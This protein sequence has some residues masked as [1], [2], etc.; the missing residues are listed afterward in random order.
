LH[1]AR[2]DAAHA[3]LHEQIADAAR[4]EVELLR[5]AVD[6]AEVELG[7]RRERA[8]EQARAVAAEAEAAAEIA[9]AERELARQH[10]L[11]AGLRM[12]LSAASAEVEAARARL[13]AAHRAV[14]RAASEVRAAHL[15]Q[16]IADAAALESELV[17]AGQ[18]AA[19]L[20]IQPD[21][22]EKL[23]LALRDQ[24]LEE[25]R[26]EAAAVTITLRPWGSPSAADAAPDTDGFTPARVDPP[27]GTRTLSVD[28]HPV[29]GPLALRFSGPGELRLDGVATLSVQ[30]GEGLADRA[31]ALAA[32]RARVA[33]CLTALDA[34]TAEAARVRADAWRAL[35]AHQ[36][37][38][39]GRL[40]LI[41]PEGAAPLQA[42]LAGLR[43]EL[44]VASTAPTPEDAAGE[45]RA[46]EARLAALRAQVD[47]TSARDA[48]MASAAHAKARLRGATT[49]RVRL[50]ARLAT[51]DDTR[52][53]HELA[54]QRSALEAALTRQTAAS[55]A[56]REAGGDGPARRVRE[57][58]LALEALRARSADAARS[59]AE[60]TAR[61]LAQAGLADDLALAEEAL[62]SAAA[63][64]AQVEREAAAAHALADA[65]EA[66]LASL[67]DRFTEPVRQVITPW[68]EILFPGSDLAVD[69]DSGQ[70]TG[71][72]TGSVVERFE[73]LSA[74]AREQLAIL[75][76]LGIG[77]V[78]AG[79]RRLPV[80]LDDALVNADPVRR[81]R[82]LAVL[83][84]ACRR[85][86][87]LVFTC[88]DADFDLLGADWS[89]RVQGR[90]ARG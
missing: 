82:M 35:I 53:A 61:L 83:R 69:A 74:G 22:L 13:D 86:Q 15:R 50:E 17:S 3:A 84:E 6:R 51:G 7:Q 20:R 89:A 85:L 5:E 80:I 47:D 2:R 44:D 39:R 77:A 79:P 37:S 21:L 56:L 73:D 24:E 29:L 55:A 1:A 67:Q 23:E 78:L 76:R 9:T 14:H 4:R 11:R 75:V 66:S 40:R 18:Q 33:R 27:H 30:P 49:D 63:R 90:P 8:L 57:L 48:A 16:R 46:A 72:R 19:A 34:P 70:I 43:A 60:G 87:I 64:R 10:G 28:G 41:A 54:A 68:V 45:L 62:A 25:A 52:A 26:A 65:M 32:A 59:V 88:H 36:T 58:E 31:E 12:E 81:A 71:L 42:E 38:L